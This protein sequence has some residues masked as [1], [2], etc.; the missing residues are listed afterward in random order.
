[1][2]TLLRLEEQIGKLLLEKGLKV[3]VAESCTGGLIC[4]LITNVSG[5]SNYFEAGIVSY[6]NYSKH[7]FLGVNTDIIKTK[8]AVSAEVALQMA[9]G[10]RKVTNVDI[11]LSVT[12]IAGPTGGSEKKPVGLV[13]IGL[14]SKE[15]SVVREFNFSGT[16]LEIKE[17]AAIEALKLLLAYL[18]ERIV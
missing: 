18:E 14:S 3:A 7:S 12:G 8:G 4:H 5:S 9:E 10:V 17:K 1:M 2:E 6:S 16:R 13:Y 15:R 11:G